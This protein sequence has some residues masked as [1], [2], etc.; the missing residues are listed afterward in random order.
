MSTDSISLKIDVRRKKILELLANEGRVHVSSLSKLLGATVVTIRNDLTEL[1]KSGQLER[2]QGGAIQTK[3]AYYNL[4]FEQRKQENKLNKKAIANAATSLI[5]NGETIFINSGTTTYYT[6]I[7][8]KAYKNLNIVTNS[9]FIALELG[10]VPTFRV[11]LLGGE[12]NSQYFFT[13]GN[14]AQEQLS[15]YKADK[16]ILSMDGIGLDTG[17][18]TYHAEEAV[19]GRLMMERARQTIIVADSTKLNHESFYSVV[20]LVRDS[21]W[22]TDANAKKHERLQEDFLAK[23]VTVVFASN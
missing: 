13:Y 10:D 23:G 5:D 2:I 9:I 4:E 1:E 19:I 17:L 7:A 22:I 16:V 20:P 12:I 21:Y 8:L 3:K 11:I 15:M 18:T 14:D 6:A